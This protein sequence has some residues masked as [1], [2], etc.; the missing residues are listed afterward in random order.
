MKLSRYV[1]LIPCTIAT[2][3]AWAD[4]TPTTKTLYQVM[5][6]DKSGFDPARHADTASRQLQE[7][8]FARLY[9]Y[10]YLARPAMLVPVA[11]MAL[12]M[13]S[14]EGRTFTIRIRPQTFFHSDRVLA[15]KPREL[16]ADD[17]A[18][19]LKRHANPANNSPQRD[20]FVGKIAGLDKL[21][22]DARATGKF[23]IDQKVA[24]LAVTD[25]HTLVI[26]LTEPDYDFAY[27]LAYPAAS[28]VAPEMFDA[29]PG[30]GKPRPIS[31][32]PYR[33]DEWVAGSTM[34]LVANNTDKRKPGA[35]GV[36]VTPKV[37]RV[38]VAIES[39]RDKQW[40][41]FVNSSVDILDR[42]D[43]AMTARAIQDGKL[44]SALQSQGIQLH[45][46][47]EPEIIYYYIN[48]RDPVLGGFTEQQKAL[49]R[50]ILR[51][52]D[53]SAE[54]RDIRKGIGNI[55]YSP[56]PPGVRG[57]D[58]AYRTRLAYDPVQANKTLDEYGFKRDA[59][60]WRQMPDGSPLVV[61]FSSE[62]LD[63]VK[64]YAALREKGL[65]AIG[66][67]MEKRMQSYQE[68]LASSTKCDLAYWGS[69]WRA[70]VPTAAYFLQLLTSKNIGKT[71]LACCAS[72]TYDALFDEA[73]KLPDGPARDALYTR[74]MRMIEDDGVWQL[75][76]NRVAMTLLK[77][78]VKGY[79]RHPVL[80]S[81]WQY[82]DLADR[83]PGEPR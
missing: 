45:Q 49:R 54:I 19:S 32:G 68:N 16:T 2:S 6:L 26:Q 43:P 66:I 22:Q 25:R 31:S 71:N 80:H 47:P 70:T 59:Q 60:G 48:V 35:G 52:F 63:V 75:G 62:P 44:S 46:A 12:P 37:E 74:M 53:V 73:K 72:P 36:G 81:A 77:P 4:N 65:Q 82:L 42:L 41:Q 58:P 30:D 3:L 21:E 79:V 38:H 11:A 1:F 64:P 10:D 27:T 17:V 29:Q 8:V 40:Q 14:N 76:T 13:V 34:V 61:T 24:G 57:H 67:K 23:D 56:L 5:S 9:T 69:T 39:D 55:G 50:A 33:L 51:S 78:R 7:A 20:L 83:N 18:Y 28:I 15:N